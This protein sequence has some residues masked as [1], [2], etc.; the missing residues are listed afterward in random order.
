MFRVF[1]FILSSFV[2]VLSQA[3]VH[4]ELVNANAYPVET[5]AAI[6]QYFAE[7]QKSL[8][9]RI[10]FFKNK[11][12]YVQFKDLGGSVLQLVHPN[13]DGVIAG[14]VN[15]FSRSH[16]IT[17]NRHIISL[18]RDPW[19]S[20]YPSLRHA[21][22]R[23]LAKATLLHELSHI[24]DFAAPVDPRLLHDLRKCRDPRRY[25]NYIPE[26]FKFCNEAL[27][28]KGKVSDH[29][30]FRRQV[31]WINISRSDQHPGSPNS[32][33]FK[34]ANEYFAVNFEYFLLDPKFKCR[35]PSLYQTYK[36]LFKWAPFENE[37]CEIG[38]K[39]FFHDKAESIVLDPRRVLSISYLH[40]G[41]GAAVMSNWGHSML[42][43]VVCRRD[44]QGLASHQ[45]IVPQQDF[46]LDR[47]AEW[48]S[49]HNER[50]E[51]LM[52]NMPQASE[53]P[54]LDAENLKIWE[55]MAK[56]CWLIEFFCNRN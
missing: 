55:E 10:P 22:G 18:I 12:V 49:F 27:A 30:D 1:I 9:P 52:Q 45:V 19:W 33:E 25:P 17:L 2:S 50:R 39:I 3:Q 37:N 46:K 21:S 15:T 6:H 53:P 4:L 36:S 20:K 43:I 54:E 29:P 14:Y 51:K 40:A 8:P 11:V 23:K 32:Y 35:R 38:Y 31:R 5:R 13:S 28:F 41:P 42:R 47:S 16:T 56:K 34:N 7:A 48:E 26:Y 24:I 44:L